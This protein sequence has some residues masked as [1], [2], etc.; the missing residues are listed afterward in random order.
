M[1]AT[2]LASL[3]LVA[4]ALLAPVTATAQSARPGGGKI[5]GVERD[6]RRSGH[7]DDDDDD[8]G[9]FLGII[10]GLFHS[11]R[12]EKSGSDVTLPP[13]PGRGY[14]EYPYADTAEGH[15]F[16]REHVLDG[17]GFGTLSATYFDDNA[18]GGTLQAG[19]VAWEGAFEE[20]YASVEWTTY[21]EPTQTNVDRLHTL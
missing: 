6:A 11:D 10:I 17:H 5:D 21:R 9:G 15:P 18:I 16:L 13:T 8:D 3:C 7:H 14:Q 12:G 1:N 2:R 19:Q 20:A 4:L